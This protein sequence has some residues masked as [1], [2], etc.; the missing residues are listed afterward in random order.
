MSVIAQLRAG[1]DWRSFAA[2]YCEDAAPLTAMGRRER[3]FFEQ[4]ER[5]VAR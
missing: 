5:G 2:E 1:N 3:A 4:R